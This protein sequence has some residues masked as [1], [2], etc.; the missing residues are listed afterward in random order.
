MQ[1]IRI[2]LLY[3]LIASISSVFTQTVS[4]QTAD[5]THVQHLNLVVKEDH[6]EPAQLE[7][8]AGK[9][10]ELHIDF[11]ASP[12]SCINEFKSPALGIPLTVLK[13][14]QPSVIRFFAK[15]AGTF[16]FS[17][18][19]GMFKGTVLVKQ[20]EN[21]KAEDFIV[22]PP[23]LRPAMFPVPKPTLTGKT[24]AYDLFIGDTTFVVKGKKRG[25]LAINGR[26]PAPT[27][28]FE[29]GDQAVIR[30]HNTLNE[31]TSLHWHGIILPADMDGVSYTNTAPILAHSTHTF[32]FPILQSGTY[33]Y[34]SHT[35][36]QEQIGLYGAIVIHP[37]VKEKQDIG[38]TVMKEKTIVLSEW[39]NES[40]HD[41]VHALKWGM[42]WYGVQKGSSQSYA[43]ALK[44]G[45]LKDR[46]KTDLLRMN[47]MD[48]SDVY[49]D[50]FWANGKTNLDFSDVKAGETVK[51][52]IVN[53]GASTYFQLQFAGGKI[54]V[55]SADGQNIVPIE[56]DRLEMA[57]AETYDIL[58]TMP[59]T[60]GK[61]ELRATAWDVSGY[62]S[63]WLGEGEKHVAPTIPPLDYFAMLH[64]MNKMG[65]W[66]SEES[67]AGLGKETNVLYANQA[68]VEAANQAN[69]TNMPHHMG[70]NHN[71]LYKG[72]VQ[73]H[74][75]TYDELKAEAP[76]ALNPENK[77]REVRLTF[78]GNMR[79]YIWSFNGIPLSK[80]DKIMI[81]KGETVRFVLYN[82]TMMRHPFHLHGHFFRLLNGQGAYS[83]LKHTFDIRPMQ[84]QTIEF[85]ADQEKDWV[86]HCHILYHMASGMHRIMG[87][88]G[89]TSA[90]MDKNNPH[91]KED[92]HVFPMAHIEA[93]SSGYGVK[94]GLNSYYWQ[95]LARVEGNWKGA[96]EGE[97]V[98]HRFLGKPQLWT[99]YIGAKVERHLHTVAGKTTGHITP[100]AVAGVTYLM[101]FFLVADARINSELKPRLQIS[102][103]HIPLTPRLGLG[104]MA[105]TDKEAMAELTFQVTKK[106]GFIAKADNHFGSGI[107]IVF[108]N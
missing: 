21:P 62:S 43:E 26:V 67:G 98:F 91:L 102:R 108:R 16:G 70:M 55:I 103:H 32:T 82:A 58:L 6:Y 60:P 75:L 64:E 83:P 50:E 52:R 29:E 57:V 47:P 48:I 71:I 90:E 79:R 100:T 56:T 9:W 72:E 77:I 89:T 18:G 38:D 25:A 85:L 23:K 30:V 105:N 80:S 11:Q 68:E 1:H 27:L 40:T 35:M 46:I 13:P 24:V 28:F 42:D 3:F 4:A 104:F 12:N 8:E 99:A 49:Y 14:N 59:P 106:W 95:G 74:L 2:S 44:A 84:T 34:H 39:T 5:T 22:A 96:F 61:Y 76:T 93:F 41:V 86:F 65:D 54:K 87:Y 101:P 81:R 7:V 88:E 45:Y 92:Q 73:G 36:L 97:A 78:T 37:Q 53:G 94:Y 20:Y 69:S 33:W 19:M 15:E 17:C 31:E 107:G 10:V 66:T 51:L 63:I